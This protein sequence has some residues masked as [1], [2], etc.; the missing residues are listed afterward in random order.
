MVFLF[1]GQIAESFLIMNTLLKLKKM[2]KEK[3]SEE[4]SL[5]VLRQQAM[6]DF[7]TVLNSSDEEVLETLN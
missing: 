2:G 3:G 6:E 4:Q 7:D 5:D 1:V